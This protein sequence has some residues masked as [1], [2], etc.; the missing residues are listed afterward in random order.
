M[1]KK[2]ILQYLLRRALTPAG[3]NMTRW[4]MD[5]APRTQRHKDTK[6]FIL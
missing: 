5:P 4:T 2:N 1:N 6:F 3:T